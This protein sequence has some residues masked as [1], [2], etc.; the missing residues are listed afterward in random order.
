MNANNEVSWDLD[1]P[2]PKKNNTGDKK[3][4]LSGRDKTRLNPTRAAIQIKIT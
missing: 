3:T 4:L 2:P 1:E